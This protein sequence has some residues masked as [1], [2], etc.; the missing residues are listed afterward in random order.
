MSTY[1][2][3]SDRALGH[4]YW[5]S[6]ARLS[7][8]RLA[9]VASG[10]RLAHVCPF[11]K[12]VISYSSDEG[13][14]WTPPTV[15]MDTPLDDRDAGIC[16][17]G[18]TVI[19]TSFTLSRDFQRQWDSLRTTEQNGVVEA[20]Q[21]LITDEDEEKYL[22]A[23]YVVSKDGGKTF[24]EVRRVY[25]SSPH[26]PTVLN[27]GTIFFFG[28]RF[29]MDGENGLGKVNEMAIVRSVDGENF[30]TPQIVDVPEWIKAE[31]A[32][33][34][35][36]AI[37]LKSGKI[38]IQIRAQNPKTGMFSIVQ[39]ESY[40]NGQTFENWRVLGFHGSPPQLLQHSSGAVI[41]SYGYRAEPFGCRARVSADEGK[42]WG[43]EIILC[44]D[45]LSS[46]VGYPCTVEAKDGGLLTI[47]YK[48]AK[49]DKN[50]CIYYKKWR[51]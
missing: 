29:E 15:I 38:L 26:G 27:D 50:K 5:P 13:E 24:G 11:G 12:V 47:Y 6:V 20:W 3:K 28:K 21:K 2:F 41:M 45:A 10:Y 16:V 51:I 31:I 22:G 35:P 40:D 42:T 48:Q 44:D 7:D 9:A 49:D 8:G 32:L 30:S 25:V 23:N 34:E 37:Q 17:K 4:F 46:D 18:D 19:V 36:Y 39:T 33:S 43:E 1:V 14:T